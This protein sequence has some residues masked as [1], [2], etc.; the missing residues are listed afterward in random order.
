M[1]LL[2]GHEARQAEATCAE[3]LAWLPGV[4]TPWAFQG[5]QAPNAWTGLSARSRLFMAAAAAGGAAAA[6]ASGV[7]RGTAR[8]SAAAG[9]GRA[10]AGPLSDFRCARWDST[11]HFFFP[12]QP[13][14]KFINLFDLFKAFD[15][16]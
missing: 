5:P 3:G 13:G 16:Y 7:R 10:C 9:S 15:F 11:L 6:A 1:H 8:G 4:M 2:L 14:W 12:W